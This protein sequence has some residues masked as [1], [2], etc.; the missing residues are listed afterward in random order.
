MV[1]LGVRP[2]TARALD[3]SDWRDGWL[4]IAKAAK[5][6]NAN[7][8]I[9]GTKTARVCRLP[10]AEIA[11]DLEDWLQAHV[12][13]ADL[14]RGRVPLFQNPAAHNDEKR[15]LHTALDRN[16][17]AACKT[18]GVKV[19]LYEGTKH[20]LGTALVSDGVDERVVQKL[21]GHAD[22]RSTRRYVVLSDQGMIDASKRRR[23]S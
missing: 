18:V 16:W 9:R 5:G 23:D 14:L 11:P 8:E 7:A 17:A 6:G 15:W 3:V 2:G 12:R 22:V 20:S 13:P 1:R 4:M 21:F 19:G 10:I